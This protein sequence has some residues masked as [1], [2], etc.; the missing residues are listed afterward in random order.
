MDRLRIYLD[1]VKLII[2]EY[3]NDFIPVFHSKIYIADYS[4]NQLSDSN[5]WAVVYYP[6]FKK[7]K[8]IESKIRITEY[9]TTLG[10]KQVLI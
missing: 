3:D 7:I 8:D 1:H 10:F 5:E 9:F 4:R 6:V 2:K